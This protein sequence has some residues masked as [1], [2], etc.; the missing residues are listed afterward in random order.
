MHIECGSRYTI[1]IKD[2]YEQARRVCYLLWLFAALLSAPTLVARVC[3]EVS[4]HKDKDKTKTKMIAILGGREGDSILVYPG[5]GQ[6]VALEVNLL[7][8]QA[9]LIRPSIQSRPLINVPLCYGATSVKDSIMYLMI[10]YCQ[11]AMV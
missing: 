9:Y 5:L 1:I 4:K 3:V 7:L 8:N 2:N 10:L 6:T 11:N